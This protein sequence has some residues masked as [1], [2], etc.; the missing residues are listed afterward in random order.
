MSRVSLTRVSLPD[1][2]PSSHTVDARWRAS[3]IDGRNDH[4]PVTPDLRQRAVRC[5]PVILDLGQQ[6]GAV[7]VLFRASPCSAQDSPLMASGQSGTG[8]GRHIGQVT[9]SRADPSLDRR[10]PAAGERGPRHPSPRPGMRARGVGWGTAGQAARHSAPPFARGAWGPGRMARRAAR[11]RNGRHGE[12]D[13]ARRPSRRGM[14]P[15]LGR[16]GGL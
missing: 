8:L 13:E 16:G 10:H 6:A 3:L 7:A 2:R 1:R 5:I 12:A 15:P 11:L 14:P 9:L 4:E